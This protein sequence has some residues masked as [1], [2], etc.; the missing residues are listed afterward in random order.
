MKNKIP[1][2]ESQN[3]SLEILEQG[4]G[5]PQAFARCA[6]FDFFCKTLLN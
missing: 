3:G 5:F 2:E 4:S 6:Y 1:Y